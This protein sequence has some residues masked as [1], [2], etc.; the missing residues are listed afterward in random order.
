MPFPPGSRSLAADEEMHDLAIEFP[1]RTPFVYGSTENALVY[2]YDS[3]EEVVRVEFAITD[4]RIVGR[5]R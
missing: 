4:G 2:T 3:S 1:R 5:A